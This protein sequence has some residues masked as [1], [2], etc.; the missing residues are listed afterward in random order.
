MKRQRVRDGGIS[1]GVRGQCEVDG[2]Q[3]LHESASSVVAVLESHI[4]QGELWLAVESVAFSI[5]HDKVLKTCADVFQS[6]EGALRGIFSVN[7]AVHVFGAD[8]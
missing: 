5:V 1:C 8:L 3:L 7:V 2:K 6:K 4:Q